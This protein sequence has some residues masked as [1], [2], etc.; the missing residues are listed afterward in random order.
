M[1]NTNIVNAVFCG[2]STKI[3]SACMSNPPV[4]VENDY[5]NTQE[6]EFVNIVKT[7]APNINILHKT[8][9]PQ[10][11]SL[12]NKHLVNKKDYS[13]TDYD[14]SEGDFWMSGYRFD[15]KVASKAEIKKKNSNAL[16]SYCAGSITLSS[17]YDFHHN[18][19][20]SMYLC[21][22]K[23]WSRMFI[24][25]ADEVWNYVTNNKKFDDELE[26]LKILRQKNKALT[27]EVYITINELPTT[28]YIQVV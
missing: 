8:Q 19:G 16:P 10:Y 12:Y 25:D 23:D 13:F 28:A 24:V 20:L 21:V 6:A 26:K 2:Y 9:N 1:I 14:R 7:V 17:V 3:K 5:A 27:T 4:N 15:L 11:L 18:D 22:N